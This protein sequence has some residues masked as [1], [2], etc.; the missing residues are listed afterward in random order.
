M[1]R[2]TNN[3][4]TERS[5]NI[6]IIGECFVII[7]L[8]CFVKISLLTTHETV[9]YFNTKNVFFRFVMYSI[10]FVVL[11]YTIL[12]IYNFVVTKFA[13]INENVNYNLS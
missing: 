4:K 2:R 3:E 11:K 10:I 9:L 13:G 1:F 8:Y 6:A 7:L 5:F 12:F